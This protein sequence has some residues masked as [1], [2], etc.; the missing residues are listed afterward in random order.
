MSHITKL[1]LRIIMNRARSRIRPEIG[2]EQCGFVQDA[3]KR[4]AIF[5]IRILSERAI[6]MQKD[7]FL[8]FVDYTKAFE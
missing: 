8:C 2:K 3:G 5:I 6:E 7:L 1:I 4:N